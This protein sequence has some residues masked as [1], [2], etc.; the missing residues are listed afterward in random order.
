MAIYV[1]VIGKNQRV[2]SL[3]NYESA[4]GHLY[5]GDVLF[6]GYGMDLNSG[7]TFIT[8]TSKYLPV[9]SSIGDPIYNSDDFVY[10]GNIYT[11]PVYKI[12]CDYGFSED[13]VLTVDE[14]TENTSFPDIP[15]TVSIVISRFKNQP[16]SFWYND[17]IYIDSY[18]LSS[19]I[20]V[21]NIV[22]KYEI[23]GVEGN[24]NIVQKDGWTEI[25][26]FGEMTD[27]TLILGGH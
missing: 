23:T 1:N 15:Y 18:D 2:I 17:F 14:S 16:N 24:F 26:K 19:A 12:P 4:I 6:L 13:F 9:S 20:T 8:F 3:K 7:E 25:S 22:S 21:I 5:C 11:T 10:K 27:F